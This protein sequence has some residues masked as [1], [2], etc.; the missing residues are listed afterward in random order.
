MAAKPEHPNKTRLWGGVRVQLFHQRVTCDPLLWGALG[1]RLQQE[2]AGREQWTPKEWE[3]AVQQIRKEDWGVVD[4]GGARPKKA[5]KLEHSAVGGAIKFGH[6]AVGEHAIVASALDGKPMAK[7]PSD[8]VERT[9]SAAGEKQREVGQMAGSAVGEE[10]ARE[11]GMSPLIAECL[12]P[13]LP[14]TFPPVP[15]A[16]QRIA[17][18][19]VIEIINSGSFGD[20][21][22]AVKSS[23]G[24]LFAIQ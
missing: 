2:R 22:K 11:G 12:S 24:E 1:N 10:Q 18:Y 21:Y 13:G 7:V 3:R 19:R 17:G 9:R 20:V 16:K 5:I 6:S 4:H 14:A 8:V 15:I 23:S